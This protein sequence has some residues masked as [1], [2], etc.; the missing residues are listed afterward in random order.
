MGEFYF[1]S[2]N[3]FL[4]RIKAENFVWILLESAC[5]VFVFVFEKFYPRWQAK[6]RSN[7]A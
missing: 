6:P 3:A 4:K 7:V 1:Y 2:I 5:C